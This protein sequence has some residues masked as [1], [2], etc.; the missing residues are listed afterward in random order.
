MKK[1]L[2]VIATFCITI[3]LIWANSAPKYKQVV[4]RIYY[5]NSQV[6]PPDHLLLSTTTC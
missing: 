6:L 3:R 5:T 4:F 2:H 1:N